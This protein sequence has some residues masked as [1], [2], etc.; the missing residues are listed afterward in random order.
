M[1]GAGPAEACYAPACPG[2][3]ALT[4][5]CL[6]DA[7]YDPACPS[8]D[9]LTCECPADACY[10]PACPGYDALICLG[11][12]DEDIGGATGS[13]VSVGT[14]VGSDD[15]LPQSCAAGGGNDHVVR[16]T[17]VLTGDYTIDTEG[18]AYDTALAVFASCNPS[19]EMGCDD[20]SGTGLLSSLTL[21]LTAG[22]TIY[23]NIG[24]WA[25]N[26]GN[27]IL[28][29][30]PPPLPPLPACAEE[31]L[32]WAVGASLI[33]GTTVGDDDD[34]TQSCGGGSSGAD[35]VHRWIAPVTGSFTFDTNGSA[36]DTVLTLYQNDC[37][38]ELNCDDDGGIGLQ[39]SITRDLLTGDEILIVVEGWVANEGNYI[40][41]ITEN[42]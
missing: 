5:E 34:L 38:T 30:T 21:P 1:T 16:F 40:I 2:Y 13:A 20:D 3:D 42:P 39:S 35:R 19:S 41:N 4:C 22:Q 23:I 36:Y 15:D 28:N 6:A 33:T 7:C 26:E 25:G 27:F 37:T 17:P 12:Y 8:Y 29:I 11:C 31:D 14:T 10:D 32:G 18:S 9:A 24:A